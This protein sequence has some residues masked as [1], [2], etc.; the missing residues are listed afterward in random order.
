MW[1]CDVFV[2]VGMDGVRDVC[3]AVL[4]ML[5]FR[6]GRPSWE[7]MGPCCDICL[8]VCPRWDVGFVGMSVEIY[9]RMTS[10]LFCRVGCRGWVSVLFS[11]VRIA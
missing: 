5:G 7:W 3:L 8:V 4:S 2:L 10:A 11:F 9:I 1:C 6:A